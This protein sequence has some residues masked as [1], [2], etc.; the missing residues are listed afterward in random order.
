MSLPEAFNRWLER[1]EAALEAI[2]NLLDLLEANMR[3]LEAMAAEE[4]AIDVTCCD[5]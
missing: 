1:E 2:E 4:T 5:S 3:A